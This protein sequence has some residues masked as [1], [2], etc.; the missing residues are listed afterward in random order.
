MID[1]LFRFFPYSRRGAATFLR[2]EDTPVWRPSADVP[3]SVTRRGAGG[4]IISV[5]N[6]QHDFHILGPGDAMGIDRGEVVRMSP[7]PGSHVS[8]ANYLTHIEF[9]HPD[10]PWL[11]T[12]LKSQDR[13]PPWIALIVIEQGGNAP[14]VRP[15][16]P[17]PTI[18][19][20]PADLPDPTDSW[21]WAHVHVTAGRDDDIADVLQAGR[22]PCKVSRLICPRRLDPHTDYVACVVP[23]Y[24]PGRISGLGKQVEWKPEDH[25]GWA[26]TSASPDPVTLPVFHHW[27]FRTGPAGDFETLA[28]R[29]SGFDPRGTPI[30]QRTALVGTKVSRLPED[31]QFPP[32]VIEIKTAIAQEALPG[33]FSPIARVGAEGRAELQKSLKKL[34]NLTKAKDKDRDEA[35]GKMRHVVGPPIYGKWHAQKTEITYDP[36]AALPEPAGWLEEIN[37]DPEMR[38]AAALGTRVVQMDQEVLIADA[39]RQLQAVAEANRLARWSQVYMT[40][41]I[42]LHEKRLAMRSPTSLLLLARPSLGRLRT[43]EV[44]IANTLAA[45]ALPQIAI[46]AN[47]ARSSRYATNALKRSGL[48]DL[49]ASAAVMTSIVPKMLSGMALFKQ[50]FRPASY[51]A[52]AGFKALFIDAGLRDEVAQ[53]L[54]GRSFD[55]IADQATDLPSIIK[56]IRDN[57]RV[58][59]EQRVRVRPDAVEGGHAGL[60][61]N[62]VIIHQIT[63]P[64]VLVAEGVANAAIQR[65]VTVTADQFAVLKTRTRARGFRARNRIHVF[66][67]DNGLNEAMAIDRAAIPTLLQQNP[68]IRHVFE[69]EQLVVSDLA[70]RRFDV[71]TRLAPGEGEAS[72]AFR[73]YARVKSALDLK[74]NPASDF[75]AS[76]ILAELGDEGAAIL[77]T[78]PP[79][80]TLTEQRAAFPPLQQVDPDIVK[81]QV[82]EILEPVRQYEK[83]LNWA[84]PIEGGRQIGL[85]RR[86][87][88]VHQIMFAPQFP[89]PMYDRLKRLD[90][91]WVL[92]HGELLP[93]NSLS[94]FVTNARF[95]EAFLIGA[96][97]EMMRELQWRRYPTDLMGTCFAH[98][99]S[100]GTADIVPIHLW[101]KPLGQNSPPGDVNPGNDTVVV[102]RGD[103]LR[104]YPNTDIAAVRGRIE[105][106]QLKATESLRPSYMQP[107]GTDITVVGFNKSREELGADGE[108]CWYIALTQP[109]DEPKFGLDETEIKDNEVPP[110]PTAPEKMSWQN[111]KPQIVGNHLVAHVPIAGQ[112]AEGWVVDPGQHREPA[113]SA[114]M[115]KW[116]ED[117]DAGQIASLLYQRPFQVLLKARDYIV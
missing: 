49:P 45:T 15:G 71:F 43:D 28:Q 88:P 85:P 16:S 70:D 41:S 109:T 107:L 73:E 30:G 84:I 117:S 63:H 101:S 50:R 111:M 97:Y 39:W 113:N 102:I 12:P 114:A 36:D 58:A 68:D 91:N 25:A 1:Y 4:E 29:L 89:Q 31:T 66:N 2:D 13:L 56:T 51:L 78:L 105:G 112:P 6:F 53:Y 115:A 10:L 19:V 57:I 99:W 86:R 60:G 62:Q 79:V 65:T 24:E 27:H 52:P 34:I 100:A 59:P 26:W 11:F 20:S 103:L 46:S 32:R 94:I 108:T 44:T 92:G 82:I 96:N 110:P 7:P 61:R 74:L 90:S 64:G 8:S 95:V 80:L 106:K 54:E 87:S 17:N 5:D 77:K 81:A 37:L 67:E 23:T 18:T 40:A 48:P 98:F 38:A 14:K 72:Q 35:D 3:L 76:P 75:S 55:D 83:M 9:A 116:G 21:A 93:N 69:Q 104:V 47:F 22:A 33:P 42:K